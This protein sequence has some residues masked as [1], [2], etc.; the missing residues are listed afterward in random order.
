MEQEVARWLHTQL[1]YNVGADSTLST[2][3]RGSLKGLWAFLIANYTSVDNKRHVQQVLARHRREQEAARR[4]PEEQ[5]QAVARRERL[6][7][8]RKRAAELEHTLA[9]LQV[10]AF[11]GEVAV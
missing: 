11:G 4:A 10:C 3:C 6:G 5:R 2:N 8:L 1:G 7:Q 9:S